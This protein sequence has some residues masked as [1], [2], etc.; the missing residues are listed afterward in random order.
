[1]AKIFGHKYEFYIGKA[2]RLIQEHNAPTGYEQSIPPTIQNPNNEVS[3][4]TGGFVDYRTIPDQHKLITNPFQMEAEVSYETPASGAT[5]PQT[6]SFKLYNISKE[7]INFIEKNN[8]VILKAGYETD[9]DL[10]LA[11]SGTVGKVSTVRAGADLVTTII[12]KDGGNPINSIRWVASFPEG[13]TYNFVLLQMIKKF[14]DNGVPLGFFKENDRTIQSLQEPTAYS[15]KLSKNLSELCASLDYVWFISKGALYV[16]PKDLPRQTDFLEVYPNNI[17]GT[18]SPVD[19]S[20]SKD[21]TDASNRASGIKFSIYLNA[22]FGID[23]YIKVKEGEYAGDYKPSKIKYKMNW[24][25][26]PWMCDIEC[27]KV[28][29]YG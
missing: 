15:G 19:E 28:V 12:A 13:I 26:G 14:K 22:E 16:Q 6:A 8:V 10:P 3:L 1:M 9:G 4:L 24:K 5:K 27:A 11:F 29:T 7:T 23:K 25:D 21:A 18:V 2:G 20:L 17:I